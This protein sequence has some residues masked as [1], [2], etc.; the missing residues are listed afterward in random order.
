[1]ISRRPGWLY[2]GDLQ[3][4]TGRFLPRPTIPPRKARGKQ[5]GN[6]TPGNPFLLLVM[7][8]EAVR[9]FFHRGID[10]QQPS[11]ART[12]PA[13]GTILFLLVLLHCCNPLLPVQASQASPRQPTRPENE[14][15][16]GFTRQQ[17]EHSPLL[18]DNP[19]DLSKI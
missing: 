13:Y 4:G 3:F 18:P 7:E 6:C 9:F 17:G 11:H 15:G 2:A 10:A 19:I 8:S 12:E 14:A 1:M 16:V 5:R